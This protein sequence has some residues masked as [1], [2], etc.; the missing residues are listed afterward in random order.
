M[1]IFRT[2]EIGIGTSNT[3]LGGKLQIKAPGALS[4][5]I[6]FK[7]RNSA[8][9]ADLM[10]VGGNSNFII[11]NS[12]Q[13]FNVYTDANGYKQLR[14][15]S[16]GAFETL[17][18]ST[19]GGVLT[20]YDSLSQKAWELTPYGIKT[21]NIQSGGLNGVT[22]S[23]LSFIST[24]FGIS[25]TVPSHTFKVF[26]SSGSGITVQ[27][28]QL[29][30]GDNGKIV[31]QETGGNVLIGTTT[32]VASSKLTVES[33]TQGFLPPRMTTTQKNAIATPASGLVVYDTTL[34]KLCVRGAAAWETIT[35]I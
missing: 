22:Y 29:F 19:G 1:D 16:S 13:Y 6:A 33:T 14:F 11:G 21:N 20:G 32:D 10:T 28:M 5:D 17:V 27:R 35:S 23:P 24:Y 9:T 8:G 3:N 18:T 12:T 7:I 4:T 25:T 34:G 30:N 31:L 2:G 15:F 26:T